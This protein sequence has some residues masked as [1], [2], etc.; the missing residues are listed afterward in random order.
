MAKAASPARRRGST[1]VATCP[2]CRRES[3]LNID[4]YLAD[5][6]VPGFG[7]PM[8]CTRCGIVGAEVRPNWHEQPER[9]SLTVGQ[10]TGQA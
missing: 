10:W 9:S 6:T 8:V 1:L 5:T 2:N 3:V 4:T 7:P